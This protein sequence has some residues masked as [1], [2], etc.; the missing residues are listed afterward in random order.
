M[1]VPATGMHLIAWLVAGVA[2]VPQ[3]FVLFW[4]S[5]TTED[6]PASSAKLGRAPEDTEATKDLR[7]PQLTFTCFLVLEYCPIAI[8]PGC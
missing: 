4:N 1:E 2:T 3:G 7:L 6:L 8:F 5:A